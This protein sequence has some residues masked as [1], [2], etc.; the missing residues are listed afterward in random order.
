MSEMLMSE[1]QCATPARPL[2]EAGLRG[3]TADPALERRA[4]HCTC[5]ISSVFSSLLAPHASAP[6]R[7]LTG[8]PLPPRRDLQAGQR[9]LSLP[10]C[11]KQSLG[12]GPG[13]AKPGVR[14]GKQE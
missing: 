10:G 4:S 11:P 14:E 8:T 7:R 9:Q 2:P 13:E 12:R 3:V 6:C 5:L 1:H